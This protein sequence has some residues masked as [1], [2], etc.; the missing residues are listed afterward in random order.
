MAEAYKLRQLLV[1]DEA[2]FGEYITAPGS[3]T[4]AKNIPILD[5]TFEPQ[6]DRDPDGSLQ[7]RLAVEAPGHKGPRRGRLRFRCYFLGHITAPSGALTE[8][9]QQDLLG[10]GLGGNSVA[11][12][13][14]TVSAGATTTS[15]P[16]AA[17]TLVRG[18]IIRLGAKGD[19]G[20]DG[21]AVAVGSTFTT[22][23]TLLTAA[24]AAPANGAVLYAAQ[25]AYHS[26]GAT[27]TTKRFGMLH[28]T[29]GAQFILFGA[30]LAAVKFAFPVGGKPTIEF[31]YEGAYWER[32]AIT[33]PNTTALQSHDCAPTAGGS[34]FLQDFGTTTRATKN[35]AELEVEMDLGLDPI[36]AIGGSGTYQY[37]VGWQRTAAKTVIRARMPWE[38]SFETWW[39][40]ENPSLVYKH[41]LA[42]LNTVNGRSVGFYAPRIQPMGSR[43]SYPVEVN[44]QNY[45][46]VAFLCNESTD[47]TNE[48]TR[49]AIRFFSS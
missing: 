8:T 16:F 15:I 40:T 33:F 34:F 9:W 7:S 12:V 21:Q 45:V 35:V 38:T 43:P 29:T 2:S 19:A 41:L 5:A 37:I 24:P 6:Q 18:G 13:G 36:A 17:A 28:A 1:N 42:T 3:A 46:D 25:M 32:Q 49:S 23:A 26:E 4:W 10:D 27:L 39:D 31:T 14:G 47:T 20:G 22:P 48:L 44:G 11:E 30:Q